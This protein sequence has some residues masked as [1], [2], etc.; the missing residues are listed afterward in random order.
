VPLWQ[1]KPLWQKNLC[2]K[3]T[4]SLSRLCDKKKSSC[5]SAFVAKKNFVAKKLRGKQKHQALA[6]IVA[7]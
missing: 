7:K 4:S 6:V 2:G 1:I 3:K 5:L